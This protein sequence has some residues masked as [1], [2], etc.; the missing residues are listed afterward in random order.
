MSKRIGWI[1]TEVT[2]TTADVTILRQINLS[3]GNDYSTKG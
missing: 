2:L 1:T 3:G